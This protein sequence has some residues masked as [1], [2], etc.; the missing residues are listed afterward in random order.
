MCKCVQ[1]NRDFHLK[2]DDML[3]GLQGVD[4]DTSRFSYLI[5]LADHKLLF[6]LAIF[7]AP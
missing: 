5:C 4:I 1:G 2:F 7:N 6:V 3:A